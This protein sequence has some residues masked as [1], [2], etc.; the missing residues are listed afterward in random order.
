M[1]QYGDTVTLVSAKER[2]YLKKLAPGGQIHLH[3]GRINCDD[4]VGRP[5]GCRV[6]TSRGETVWV[7]RST[8]SDFILK[9]PRRS[10]IVYPKDLA[11]IWVW[12]DLYP[13]CRVLTAGTGSGALLLALARAVGESGQVYGYDLR[14]DMLELSRLNLE[15]ALGPRP[16]VILRPGDVCE[17]IPERELDRVVLD[18]PEPWRAL[19]PTAEALRPGGILLAY[20][21]TIGQ[22]EQFVRAVR[23]RSDY[24]LPEVME[25]L[26]RTWHVGERSSRPNFRMVGH[27]GFLCRALR[28]VAWSEEEAEHTGSRADP[29]PSAPDE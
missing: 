1:L 25:V 14:E 24:A 7:Y 8:L 22:A 9:M 6:L 29:L 11:M 15:A 3:E 5:A 10:N 21:P 28:V 4:L 16:N 20:V 17:S 23:E 13:G 19:G 12:A 26:F 2:M 18:V 27:T